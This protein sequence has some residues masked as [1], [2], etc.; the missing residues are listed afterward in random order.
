MTQRVTAVERIPV[1]GSSVPIYSPTERPPTPIL[2]ALDDGSHEEGEEWRLR[3]NSFVIGQTQGQATFPHDAGIS[4]EHLRISRVRDPKSGWHW[5]IEDLN[6]RTGSFLRV[7]KAPLVNGAEF[8][9]A[10]TRFVFECDSR[11][12]DTVR[13]NQTIREDS[14]LAVSAGAMLRQ[15][16]PGPSA[17]FPIFDGEIVI[18]TD[19]ETVGVLVTDPF[20]SPKHTRIAKES[21]D[22]WSLEDLGTVNGTWLR[23]SRIK[24]PF[25]SYF[26]IGEQRFRFRVGSSRKG[27]NA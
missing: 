27:N 19:P 1:S 10:N 21:D 13:S 24:L 6:S 7:L 4:T 5:G 8:L 20:A 9:V 3:G 14:T 22:S 26:R 11:L 2:I 25:H 12:L 23:I 18:G 15:L 16:G 17:E